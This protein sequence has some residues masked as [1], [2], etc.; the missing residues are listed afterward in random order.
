MLLGSWMGGVS[1]IQVY[2]LKNSLQ[3]HGVEGAGFWKG[4]GERTHSRCT[5]ETWT[6]GTIA[7]GVRR[8]QE[9]KFT[10]AITK[11]LISCWNLNILS[12]LKIT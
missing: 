12:A 9:C 11:A 6:L 1:K 7:T 4:K 5:F 10:A 3:T 8:Q 2:Q